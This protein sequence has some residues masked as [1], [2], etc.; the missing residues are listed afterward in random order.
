[1]SPIRIPVAR[2]RG[3]RNFLSGPTLSTCAGPQV[4]S[5][6]R[7]TGREAD[8]PAEAAHDPYLPFEGGSWIGMLRTV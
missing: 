1:M 8:I 7:Y 4:G 5:Y 6:L 2:R 3:A